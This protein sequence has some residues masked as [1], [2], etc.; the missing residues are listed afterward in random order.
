MTK[1]Y[2]Y[3][4]ALT[5]IACGCLYTLTTRAS[6]CFLP[7]QDCEGSQ[8]TAID[9]DADE[10]ASKCAA[11]GY[12]TKKE[13]CVSP[14]H[15]GGV[16][17]HDNKWVICCDAEYNYTAPC[18]HPLVQAGKCGSL[19]MCECADL[20]KYYMAPDGQTF[21]C[22]N[23]K[24][25]QSHRNTY[26]DGN[27]CALTERD[28][29]GNT[30]ELLLY[31]RCLCDSARFSKTDDICRQEDPNK[32]CGGDTCDGTDNI[33]R[34]SICKCL[35]KF[36]KRRSECS[37]GIVRNADSCV[38]GSTE[39]V[40]PSSCC[41]CPVSSYPYD[42]TSD[43]STVKT[44]LACSVDKGCS[45]GNKDRYV[46]TECQ[47]GYKLVG[48]KC[49][50]SGCADAIRDYLAA[51]NKPEYELY[52]PGTKPT[53]ANVVVAEDTGSNNVAWEH[54]YN[55]EVISGPYFA[56]QIFGTDELTKAVKQTCTTTPTITISSYSGEGSG[57]YSTKPISFTSVGLK[58][59]SWWNKGKF[60]CKN[61]TL[62]IFHF[63]NES[64]TSL[65]YDPNLPNADNT[66]ALFTGASITDGDFVSTGYDIE[67]SSL[68]F[69]VNNSRKKA[70]DNNDMSTWYIGTEPKFRVLIQG[71]PSKRITFKTLSPTYRLEVLGSMAFNYAD[72]YVGKT[73]IGVKDG[74]TSCNGS[75]SCGDCYCYFGSSINIYNTNWYLYDRETYTVNHLYTSTGSMLGVPANTSSGKT[76]YATN[77]NAKIIMPGDRI[78]QALGA[79]AGEKNAE[80]DNGCWNKSYYTTSYGSIATATG[81][82]NGYAN[83]IC[84]GIG[85]GL[86]KS[87]N[88][89]LLVHWAG[90][91]LSNGTYWEVLWNGGKLYSAHGC[92]IC[93]DRE[94]NPPKD[95]KCA[96]TYTCNQ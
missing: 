63:Y 10:L 69:V 59:S 24:T 34:C 37:F 67:V 87:T 19:Y 30:S 93:S 80:D 51:G 14:R 73:Y 56:S 22:R 74:R 27:Y 81:N 66:F 79:R 96:D 31:E 35:D 94:N 12:T 20:Y 64:N 5:L 54:F 11:L 38:Q 70:G 60:T 47:N 25:N 26:V 65:E 72:V 58:S 44:Y 2:K 95:G 28:E 32:E 85:R 39:Y 4:A 36:S 33:T 7:D 17:P 40:E 42:S 1:L 52:Q 9:I 61:C 45:G 71:T 15:S 8:I 86:R 18:T 88:Y 77:N 57:M 55:K 84:T 50:Q 3:F 91:T 68:N 90:K 46:A 53:K 75:S 48:G 49:T 82:R 23:Y 62:D 41:D 29:D 76:K 6:V 78:Y 83:S 89:R 21:V 16:C 92:M 13:E 43:R